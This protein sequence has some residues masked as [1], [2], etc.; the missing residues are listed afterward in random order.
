MMNLKIDQFCG[1]SG[2]PDF[3]NWLKTI[4]PDLLDALVNNPNKGCKANQEKMIEIH[5]ALYDRKLENQFETFIKKRYSYLI[6]TDNTKPSSPTFRPATVPVS[7]PTPGHIEGMNKHGVFKHYRPDL[8]TFPHKYIMAGNPETL[9]ARVKKFIVDKLGID[10]IILDDY[11]YIEYFPR[12]YA[13][14]ISQI[15]PED[16][17]IY[18]YRKRME[19]AKK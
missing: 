5:R 1:L 9:Q 7:T 18:A 11:A 15:R 16:R 4:A 10:Y 8:L 12:R 6:V 17:E 2:A 13:D 3:R 19:Q 14:I